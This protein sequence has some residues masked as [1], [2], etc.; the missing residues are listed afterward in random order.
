MKDT[1]AFCA[2]IQCRVTKPGWDV[3]AATPV[4]PSVLRCVVVGKPLPFGPPPYLIM[5]DAKPLSLRNDSLCCESLLRA[6]KSAAVSNLQNFR[7]CQVLSFKFLDI[8]GR[9]LSCRASASHHPWFACVRAV[10]SNTSAHAMSLS[11]FGVVRSMLRQPVSFPVNRYS[12]TCTSP[13]L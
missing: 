10:G 11:R 13:E 3:L 4:P 8:A 6:Y 9:I 1:Y 2:A 12:M 7:L 5:S